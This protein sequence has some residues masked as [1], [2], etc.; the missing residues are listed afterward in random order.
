MATEKRDDKLLKF[1]SECQ[2]KGYTDM[3]DST[4]SLKAK[5]IANDLG[6]SYG[7]IKTLY[8]EAKNA[9]QKKA[10]SEKIVDELL[11]TCF[12]IS[13][14]HFDIYK[15]N[16][17]K[18]YALIYGEKV[19]GTPTVEVAAVK[20][21][22]I[23]Y[24]APSATYIGVSSSHIGMSTGSVTYDPGGATTTFK[25][26]E[27]G[28]VVLK[29]G[30]KD[31][32]LESVIPSSKLADAFKRDAEF[33]SHYDGKA[34]LLT[35]K[36]SIYDDPYTGGCL[37]LITLNGLSV[38]LRKMINNQLPESDQ[39][40]YTKALKLIN[41]E[42]SAAVKEAK[43][44]FE[45]ISDYKDSEEQATKASKR[46]EEV[47]Q[48]EKERAILSH[49]R[50]KRR[51]LVF[52]VLFLVVVGIVFLF[53]T[54]IIPK[55]NMNTFS[56]KYGQQRFDTFNA[57]N[58]GDTITFGSF[59]QDNNASNGEEE[60]EWLVLSKENNKILLLS[61]YALDY[62]QYH[63]EKKD[64]TWEGCSLR[65]WLN[66]EFL[67]GGFSEE[68]RNLIL[69][70]KVFAISNPTSKVEP[71][72]NTKDCVFLL[73]IADANKYFSSTQ[74]RECSPTNYAIARGCHVNSNY[75]TCE[76][77]LRSPGVRA[78]MAACVSFAGFVVND[79]TIVNDGGG[80]RPALWIN[81]G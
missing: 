22:A 38:L 41:S 20:R 25:N 43:V 60:I 35:K 67:K 44:T 21:P 48:V 49:E 54:I 71:G 15:N 39:E 10:Q 7:N 68:E 65:K 36:R 76:W 72:N 17:N 18:I 50:G 1:Y 80:V 73:S 42:S 30:K 74:A 62:Q 56:K 9:T 5:V 77:W 55:G 53:H 40:L 64:I 69:K 32:K 52:G 34:L 6:L 14:S 59:E 19:F 57:L 33:M 27:Y 2:S 13:C 63:S 24:K 11:L 31:Y 47:L 45:Y 26:T 23:E 29:I 58:V 75:D 16:S 70:S 4:H 28:H 12:T 37:P 61:K 51:L 66:G 78:N 81:L 46:Y 8:Q 79:G 3:N